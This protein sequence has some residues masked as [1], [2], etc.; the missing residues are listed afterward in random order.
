[1]NELHHQL[2][3]IV[4][5][6]KHA[7]H[8]LHDNWYQDSCGSRFQAPPQPEQCLV[9]QSWT[10]DSLKDEGSM[11]MSMLKTLHLEGAIDLCAGDCA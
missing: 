6:S 4:V 3:F 2:L 5:Y 1:M 9:S 11:L 8:V 7:G 10:R